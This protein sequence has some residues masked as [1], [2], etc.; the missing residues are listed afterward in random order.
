[1]STFLHRSATDHGFATNMKS[2]DS[3][4]MGND[5]IVSAGDDNLA[6]YGPHTD[7]DFDNDGSIGGRGAI[8][9]L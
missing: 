5:G 6:T 8:S 1:M 3:S 7:S 4:L 9:Q 2:I